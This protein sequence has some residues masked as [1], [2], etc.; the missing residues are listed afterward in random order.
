MY[1]KNLKKIKKQKKVLLLLIFLIFVFALVFL[2]EKSKNDNEIVVGKKNENV[3]YEGYK[4][5]Y[6]AGGCFWCIEAPFQETEGVLEAISGYIGGAKDKAD[7]KSVITGKTKHRESVEVIYDENKVSYKELLE[8]FFTQ[9]DPTDDGGQFT[10]RGFQYTSGIYFQNKEQ[11][12]QAEKI[13]SELVKSKKFDKSITVN[14]LPFE[15]FFK[16]EDYHQDFY[17][18]S[19]DYYK[20]Y[21]KGSGR[22]GFIEENWAKEMALIEIEKIK[23][24]KTFTESLEVDTDT[25]VITDIFSSKKTWLNFTKPS[26]ESLKKSLTEI[27]FEVTQKNETE[28]PYANEYWDNK[29]D[30]IYVDIV[31]GEPLFSSKD[32]YKSGTG[33]PSFVKTIDGIN[34]DEQ[35]EHKLFYKR[36]E[37]KSKIAKS[38]LGHIFSD[39]PISRG[40]L[41]YCVN[42][43]SLRFVP[44][45]EMEKEG[46]GELL[47][48]L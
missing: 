11:K 2:P 8:I 26:E 17:K 43:A 12:E 1:I 25:K 34:L 30:G 40:G 9:I 35:D 27:Q 36:I 10:D 22:T 44:K 5:A 37:I 24:E 47:K 39:G 45:D 13:I 7:Y 3:S 42:S 20:K 38:H 29:R 18:K 14:V 28:R 19:A 6:F 21:K 23:K 41:R 48:S 33:W 15:K 4:K 46:Y 16:A 31:S 32:K